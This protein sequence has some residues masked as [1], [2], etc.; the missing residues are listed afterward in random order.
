MAK[1]KSG[2]GK[3]RTDVLI[4]IDLLTVSK[5]HLRGEISEDEFLNKLQDYSIE[6]TIWELKKLERC[7]KD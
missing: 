3:Y 1:S 4:A 5:S 6:D 2:C 7:L